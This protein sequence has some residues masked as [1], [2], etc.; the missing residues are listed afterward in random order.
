MVTIVLKL[1]EKITLQLSQRTTIIF[2]FTLL[3]F[4][5]KITFGSLKKFLVSFLSN[6]FFFTAGL[7]IGHLQNRKNCIWSHQKFVGPQEI[8][9]IVML[10]SVHYFIT[11]TTYKK[12]RERI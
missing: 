10:K 8:G 7:A 3:N 6:R 4:F 1:M 5:K 11:I 12:F 2:V 9:N